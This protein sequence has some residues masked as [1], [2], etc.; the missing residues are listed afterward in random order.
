MVKKDDEISTKKPTKR[1]RALAP[2]VSPPP[3]EGGLD[4]SVAVLT[5]S[6]RAFKNEYATGD[7]SGP[8]VQEAVQSCLGSL[9]SPDAKSVVGRVEEVVIVPDEVQAIV[10]K[11]QELAGRVDLVLTT[12]GTGF[13]PRD[14]TPEATRQAVDRECPGL[15]A[16]V[17]NE[18]TSQQ[19]LASLSRG[20]AGIRGKC[21]VA[22]LP[23]N[24]KGVGE[25]VP[26]LLPLA[27]HAIQDLKA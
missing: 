18:C 12:G 1:T 5:V 20:T 24:P 17:T 11:I 21:L 10:D 13:A 16:F 7:L 19:P 3:P 26:V 9:Q 6:D 23:G 27:L 25:I 8:A 4:F 15:M 22:N 2:Y 14:V